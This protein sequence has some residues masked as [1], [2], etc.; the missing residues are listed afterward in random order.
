MKTRTD[1]LNFIASEIE[2]KTY[3]EIGVFDAENFNNINVETK[4]G[5]DPNTEHENVVQLTSDEFFNVENTT[6]DLIFIDGDHS[7]EQSLKDLQNSL[8]HI[9]EGGIMAKED[10]EIL[11]DMLTSLVDLLVEKGVVNQEEY[12]IKVKEKLMNSEKLTRFEDLKK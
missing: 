10:I 6:Y 9:N 4:L 11:E 2:A 8:N 3:L 7:H 5:I 12:D 1:L